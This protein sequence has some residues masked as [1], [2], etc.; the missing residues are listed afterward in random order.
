VALGMAILVSSKLSTTM[1]SYHEILVPLLWYSYC[2]YALF[3]TKHHNTM[4]YNMTKYFYGIK[5]DFMLS[6]GMIVA[7]RAMAIFLISIFTYAL[8]S[9]R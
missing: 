2:G 5:L 7:S 8:F 6:R 3:F 1:K 4:H 9:G